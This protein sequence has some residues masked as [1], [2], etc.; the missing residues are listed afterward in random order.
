MKAGGAYV[1]LDPGH[2]AE[3]LE[4]MLADSAPAAVL[5]QKQFR[6]QVENTGVPVLEIDADGPEWAD[7]PATAQGVEG[8]TPAHLAYVIYT[9]GSTG[10]PKG[11]AVPH[12]GVVNLLG[13][14]RETVG[15]GPPDRLRAGPP[16][17]AGTSR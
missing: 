13:S 6:D 7:Q 16:P 2:P 5:T 1:P 14:M 12:R 9:S 8:L 11:V 3:R 4:Y 17:R 15:M 10:R